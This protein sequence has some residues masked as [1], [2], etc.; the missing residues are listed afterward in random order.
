[1]TDFN[2]EI[3]HRYSFYMFALENIPYNIPSKQP[4]NRENCLNVFQ[5]YC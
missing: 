2:E 4:N 3:S 5:N 1:M